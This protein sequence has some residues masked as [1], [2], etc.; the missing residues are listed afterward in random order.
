VISVDWQ[1][2]HTGEKGWEKVLTK[3]VDFFPQ[4]RQRY[5]YIGIAISLNW[6]LFV[7]DDEAPSHVKD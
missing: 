7:T 1:L 4:A 3:N 2:E 5:S 6:W